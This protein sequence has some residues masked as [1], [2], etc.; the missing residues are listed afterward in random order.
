MEAAF[1][2]FGTLFLSQTLS[3]I[4]YLATKIG[5]GYVQKKTNV[6]GFRS[7]TYCL[8]FNGNKGSFI[9]W[10]LFYYGSVGVLCRSTK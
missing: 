6:M 4:D 5:E 2:E 8:N 1:S 7:Y 9:L 3:R 10:K